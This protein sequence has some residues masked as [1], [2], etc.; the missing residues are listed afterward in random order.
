MKVFI[1]DF[2]QTIERLYETQM[3]EPPT[4]VLEMLSL[5]MRFTLLGICI[6]V[7]ILLIQTVIVLFNK[8]KRLQ[9]IPLGISFAVLLGIALAMFSP[10]VASAPVEIS[11]GALQE[12]VYK[13][14]EEIAAEK[15]EAQQLAQEQAQQEG[16]AEEVT[17]T[18]DETDSEEEVE[19]IDGPQRSV[20]AQTEFTNAQLIAIDELL[21]NTECTRTLLRE[22]PQENGQ[23]IMIR[24]SDNK[25]WQIMLLQD[26]GYVYA[27]ETTGFI[28]KIE[29]YDVF[30][31][32]LSEI[33]S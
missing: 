8:Q 16:T 17:N 3:Q 2:I 7:P 26:N 4:I 33:L 19:V 10:F 25:K 23:N 27:S 1:E 11:T 18:E 21:Q 28:S 9:S 6:A 30:Y 20:V 12:I 29:D 15:A 14:P 32:E 22:L 13:T 24:L 31:A 5:V